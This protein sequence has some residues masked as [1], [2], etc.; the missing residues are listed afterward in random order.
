MGHFRENDTNRAGLLGLKEGD[1]LDTMHPPSHQTLVA[2]LLQYAR[3]ARF[4]RPPPSDDPVVRDLLVQAFIDAEVARLLDQRDWRLYDTG[5][6][7][8]YHAAQG[9]L[10]RMQA[11]AR[12]AAIVRD[13]LGPYAL[14][15]QRDPRAPCG[16]AFQRHQRESLGSADRVDECKEAIARALG[17]AEGPL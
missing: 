15:D 11:S 5:R 13:V 16:G 6:D 4:D 3:Q 17:V 8:T 1:S 12:L 7:L 9:A 14:L 10:W 2:D